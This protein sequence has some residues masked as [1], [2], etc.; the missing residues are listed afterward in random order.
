MLRHKENI[1]ALLPENQRAVSNDEYPTRY[2]IRGDKADASDT[3]AVIILDMVQLHRRAVIYAT[4]LAVVFLT[5]V[6]LAVAAYSSQVRN[7]PMDS[8]AREDQNK[9]DDKSQKPDLVEHSIRKYHFE[10]ESLDGSRVP[11][12]G[13]LVSAWTEQSSTD[14]DLLSLEEK[15]GR[16]KIMSGENKLSN[17]LA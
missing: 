12:D 17:C 2:G 11:I 1:T 6:A 16:V 5:S 7:S 4:V 3:I 8:K 10:L 15:D 9:D 13:L 14:S